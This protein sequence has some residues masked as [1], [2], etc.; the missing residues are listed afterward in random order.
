MSDDDCRVR[1]NEVLI[2]GLFL[3]DSYVLDIVQAPGRLSFMLDAVLTPDHVEYGTPLPGEQ[4]C[5][6]RGTL[7]F[8]AV[9]KVEWIAR[10]D[11]SYID[12]AGQQDLGNIDILA[13]DGEAFVVDGDWGRVRVVS[14]EPRFDLDE[15]PDLSSPVGA[16]LPWST[17]D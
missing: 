7:V 1:L 13:R 2:P 8:P 17:S 16:E 11:R 6:A 4:H 14:A 5:Y 12:A 15:P 3:R 10:T 9:K